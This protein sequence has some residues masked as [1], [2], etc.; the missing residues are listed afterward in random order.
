MWR[1]LI[2]LD[3]VPQLQPAFRHILITGPLGAGKTSLATGIGTE[4]AFALGIGRYMSAIDLVQTVASSTG[5]ANQ[6]DL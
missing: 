3:E 4:F 6:M 2:G 1:V 5:P